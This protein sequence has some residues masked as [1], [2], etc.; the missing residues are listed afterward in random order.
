MFHFLYQHGYK[1]FIDKY[2]NRDDE[3]KVFFSSDFNETSQFL[4][5]LVTLCNNVARFAKALDME[6]HYAYVIDASAT[7]PRSGGGYRDLSCPDYGEDPYYTAID[8]T[9]KF[10]SILKHLLAYFKD[11]QK[12]QAFIDGFHLVPMAQDGMRN[13]Q[14]LIDS[15]KKLISSSVSTQ[16]FSASFTTANFKGNIFDK[17]G[18]S[19]PL[20][21][22]KIP[23]NI[24]I[25]RLSLQNKNKELTALNKVF[26]DVYF[27]GVTE[28]A[29]YLPFT[30]LVEDKLT[31]EVIGGFQWIPREECTDEWAAFV[32]SPRYQRIGVGRILFGKLIEIAKELGL[33]RI[34]IEARE[35]AFSFDA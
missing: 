15:A 10:G 17:F 16:S 29:E 33:K 21:D 25:R 2:K 13:A 18:I 1:Q 19:S 5:T 12:L 9:I 31:Q 35:R 30:Y 3:V 22:K 7:E 26:Q 34:W 6:A 27:G 23:E 8:V 32:V 14:D 4:A 20:I 11:E 24:N 28:K